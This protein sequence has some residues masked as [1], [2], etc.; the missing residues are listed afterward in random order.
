VGG[1]GILDKLNFATAVKEI[2]NANASI[3]RFQEI[4]KK[5]MRK[6]VLLKILKKV[7][8]VKKLHD[9]NEVRIRQRG[10]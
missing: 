10:R 7:N 3:T 9:L 4:N 6:K 5:F 1:M 8:D 2:K